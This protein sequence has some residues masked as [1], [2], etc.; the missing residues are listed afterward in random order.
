MEFILKE[1]VAVKAWVITTLALI[2][3]SSFGLEDGKTTF[4]L[5]LWSISVT[6]AHLAFCFAIL[7]Y[8]AGDSRKSQKSPYNIIPISINP[9]L[10]CHS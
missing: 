6:V 8:F 5:D 7:R 10:R 4:D 2:M 1:M 9:S 3:L